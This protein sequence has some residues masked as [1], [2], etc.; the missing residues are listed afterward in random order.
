MNS[1]RHRTGTVNWPARQSGVVAIRE[2]LMIIVALAGLLWLVNQVFLNFANVSGD[3]QAAQSHPVYRIAVDSD[4]RHLW[5]HRRME[6]IVRVNLAT[7]EVDQSLPTSGEN[8]ST[9]AFSVDGT[10]ALLC[11][12]E[13]T[14]VLFR[15][16]EIVDVA[17]PSCGA[18]PAAFV[19]DDGA[20][21]VCVDVSGRIH[22]WRRPDSELHEFTFNRTSHAAF[23]RIGLNPAGSRLFVA[24]RDGTVSF[25][26]L[27]PGEVDGRI[28]EVGVEIEECAWSRDERRF[29]VI[30]GDFQVRTYDALTGHLV[31]QGQLDIPSRYSEGTIAKISPDGRRMVVSTLIVPE[32]YVWDLEVGKQAGR[33]CGHEKQARTLQFSS[34]SD[35]LY[36]G[37]HDGTIREWSLKTCSQ[38]RIVR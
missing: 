11:Y 33:L 10:T 20:I 25:H 6:D 9:W 1:L 22:G 14:I 23:L 19:S 38:R 4:D 21:A 8:I 36:S 17:E 30:T 5:V 15:N 24:R 13:G 2:T 32:I 7:G 35:R 26:S 28:F 3:A 34:D 27:Q 29:S 31:H 18:I 16:G 37:S 12:E